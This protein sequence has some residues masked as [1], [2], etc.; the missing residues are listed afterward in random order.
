MKTSQTTY[1]QRGGAGGVRG[2]GGVAVSSP[3]QQH[4]V[5]KFALSSVSVLSRS[6]SVLLPH[7]LWSSANADEVFPRRLYTSP[8][9]FFLHLEVLSATWILWKSQPRQGNPIIVFSLSLT[10]YCQSAIPMRSQSTSSRS[11]SRDG[12]T[13]VDTF[14]TAGRTWHNITVKGKS[15]ISFDLFW[16]G[17]R[18][19]PMSFFFGGGGPSYPIPFWQPPNAAMFCG[20]HNVA[21]CVCVCVRVGNK[22]RK[23]CQQLC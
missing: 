8:W 15:S 16:V 1:K 13:L 7:H 21:A 17:K 4:F 23:L 3:R 22:S 20:C 18:E 6:L 12:V 11:R 10:S 14:R 19:D 5:R 9:P 2:E